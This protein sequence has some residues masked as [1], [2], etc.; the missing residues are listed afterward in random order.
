MN[1]KNHKKNEISWHERKFVF[2][3]PPDGPTDNHSHERSQESTN[4]NLKS[5]SENLPSTEQM[6][7]TVSEGSP[8]TEI[9]QRFKKY[10]QELEKIKDSNPEL[11]A[12]GLTL[13]KRQKTEWKRMQEKYPEKAEIIKEYKELTLGPPDAP[14]RVRARFPKNGCTAATIFFPGDGGKITSYNIDSYQNGMNSGAIVIEG[15]K[16]SGA[17]KYNGI[18]HEAI[19]KIINKVESWIGNPIKYGIFGYSRGADGVGRT[20]RG[21]RTNEDMEN[22]VKQFPVISILDSNCINYENLIRYVRAGGSINISYIEG[23]IGH[24][25]AQKIIQYFDLPAISNQVFQSADGRVR[26]EQLKGYGKKAHGSVPRQCLARFMRDAMNY[27]GA[28]I[29]NETKLARHLPETDETRNIPGGSPP[30]DRP[31]MAPPDISDTEESPILEK[32]IDK[33]DPVLKQFLD[34]LHERINNPEKIAE[35]QKWAESQTDIEKL[36]R[37]GISAFENEKNPFEKHIRLA[38]LY[39]KENSDGS[40]TVDFQKINTA[41]MRIGAGHM[42]PPTI[43]AIR[44]YDDEGRLRFD[45]A[46]RGIR[47]GR[48]GYFVPGTNQYAF[49][50]TGYRIEILQT[51]TVDDT[52]TRERLRDEKE[53]SYREEK[54]I[55]IKDQFRDYLK[56]KGIGDEILVND[57]Y[58]EGSFDSVFDELNKEYPA[59]W[60][61]F[62]Q[63]LLDIA[64]I[65]KFFDNLIKPEDI[66]MLKNFSRLWKK[67]FG[68]PMAISDFLAMKDDPKFTILRSHEMTESELSM[69]EKLLKE[70]FTSMDGKLATMLLDL[71]QNMYQKGRGEFIRGHCEQAAGVYMRAAIKHLGI[72][73]Y[74]RAFDAPIAETAT[75]FLR[76]KRINNLN[77]SD[78]RSVRSGMVFFV[79]GGRYY[80]DSLKPGTTNRLERIPGSDRDG[81]HWFTYLGPSPGGTALFADNWGSHQTLEDIQNMVGNRSVINVHDPYMEIRKRIPA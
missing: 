67:N 59:W 39:L 77:F 50:H 10:E 20:L 79:N 74:A 46:E 27:I 43:K 52:E 81:R 13:L 5:N 66:I 21:V 18:G 17:E 56:S 35:F 3:G 53:F 54:K 34:L 32:G 75:R 60:E 41:E 7:K 70:S 65:N 38:S 33:N 1:T 71:A 68:A 2:H 63:N 29:P 4:P 9:E 23:S 36:R 76:G 14:C 28:E 73:G 72:K 64:R 49:V 47:N 58:F 25:G 78:F 62:S 24:R 19:L 57:G 12:E 51:Q 11:Y 26:V 16:S 80:G 61:D 37:A 6:E 8:K 30:I 31:P 69:N 15:T 45:R 55:F 22:F 40:F 48:I 42:L 44:V